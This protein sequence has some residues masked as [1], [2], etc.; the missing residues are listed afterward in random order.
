M[1]VCRYF[2]LLLSWK[3][4]YEIFSCLVILVLPLDCLS[5]EHNSCNTVR[6]IY[7]PFVPLDGC[8][9]FVE[10]A[11]LESFHCLARSYVMDNAKV[12]FLSRF[13]VFWSWSHGFERRWFVEQSAESSGQTSPSQCS[14]K[15]TTWSYQ[16]QFQWFTRCDSLAQRRKGKRPSSVRNT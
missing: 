1:T 5:N 4:K 7:N 8:L 13:D 12:S 9:C 16:G 6:P 10:Q 11:T 15:K 14:G 2:V 3:N